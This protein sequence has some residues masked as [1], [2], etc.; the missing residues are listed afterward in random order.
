MNTSRQRNYINEWT[1]E[2]GRERYQLL[3][4]EVYAKML[5]LRSDSRRY[6]VEY[7]KWLIGVM[8]AAH[9]GALFLISGLVGKPGVNVGELVSASGWHVGGVGFTIASGFCAW[10]N[11]QCAEVIYDRWSDPTMLIDANV[12]PGLEERERRLDPI[13]ATLFLAAAFGIIS[14]WCF[15]SGALSALRS[16]SI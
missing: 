5:Q 4:H 3:A 13:S 9:F 6:H 12:W 10:V 15:L 1:D 2:K 7:G 11:F 8:L 14:L 16:V